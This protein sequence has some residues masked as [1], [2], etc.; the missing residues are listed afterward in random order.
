MQTGPDIL[1]GFGAASANPDLP[2]YLFI[3]QFNNPNPFSRP[4]RDS[5]PNLH[6]KP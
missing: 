5:V 6:L 4:C 2:R 1:M 3:Y